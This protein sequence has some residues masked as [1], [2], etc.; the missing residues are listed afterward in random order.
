MTVSKYKNNVALAHPY[1]MHGEEKKNNF[2]LAHPYH[3][4][5]SCSKFGQILSR[6][7]GGA[8]QHERR[9]DAF[10]ESPLLKREDKN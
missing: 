4:G 5:R 10:T 8:R 3:M 1:H 7:L 6:S 9:T 2:A